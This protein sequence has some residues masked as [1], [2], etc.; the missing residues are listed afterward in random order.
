MQHNNK[1]NLWFQS[2]DFPTMERLTHLRQSN[3][4]HENGYQ[5]FVDACEQW[6]QET[7]HAEKEYIYRI[8]S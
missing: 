6:W 7:P 1:Y 5:D 8:F 2:L 3:F 4:S